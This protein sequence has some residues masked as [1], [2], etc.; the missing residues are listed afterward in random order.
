MKVLS[1]IVDVT[2]KFV[3]TYSPNALIF[4]TSDVKKNALYGKIA[5]KIGVQLQAQS[6]PH[7]DYYKIELN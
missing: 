7:G 3:D 4:G 6:G 2:K 5:K 1:S